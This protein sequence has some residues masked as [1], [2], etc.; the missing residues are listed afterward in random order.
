MPPVADLG[1]SRSGETRVQPLSRI[2][3]T[4]MA[5]VGIV[6]FF[7]SKTIILP[8]PLL[9]R[10]TRHERLTVFNL[11]GASHFQGCLRKLGIQGQ[12]TE[13]LETLLCLLELPPLIQFDR[14]TPLR[15]S[16]PLVLPVLPHIRL[17]HIEQV[18]G[19][20][21][22]PDTAHA[23]DKNVVHAGPNDY[24]ACEED[25][26]TI[27]LRQRLH[28]RGQHY[29]WA[30]QSGR[31]PV[32][33]SHSSDDDLTEVQPDSHAHVPRPGAEFAAFV[34]ELSQL[35]LHCNGSSNGVRGLFEERH[36]TVAHV[37]V[38]ETVETTDY[39]VHSGEEVVYP[40]EGLLRVHSGGEGG[41]GTDVGEHHG[42]FGSDFIADAD[43][44][45]ILVAQELQELCRHEVRNR[46]LN[47]T[48]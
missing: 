37:L 15:Q 39:R 29:V 45:Y 7:C 36:D 9:E 26:Y 48:P 17:E 24:G 34:V 5:P 1:C 8:V 31:Q 19:T 27:T 3:K 12:L 35:V 25:L 22:A 10:E 6:V 4:E 46:L 47:G 20:G 41:E 23:T 18:E 13:M 43:L 33:I 28:L 32:L 16:L 40:V 38:D 44:C 14:G 11:E 42:Q 30:H 21:R 2:W